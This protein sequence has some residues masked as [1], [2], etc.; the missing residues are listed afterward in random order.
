MSRNHTV[1]WVAVLVVSLIGFLFLFKT[2][3]ANP[4]D[5][6][7]YA[8]TKP[9][10]REAYAFATTNSADL[11]GLPCSCGCGTPEGAKAHGSRV[12]TRGLLDCFTQGDIHN[13]GAW[14]SHASECGLCY[15]DALFAKKLYAEGNSKQDVKEGLLEMQSKRTFSTEVVYS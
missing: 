9:A 5:L 13:G 15:E 3:Y 12:H 14:D 2:A 10:I 8:F 11:E 1:L 6:P 7:N 4:L